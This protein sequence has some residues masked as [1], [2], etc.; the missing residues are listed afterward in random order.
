M[1][2]ILCVDTLQCIHF[3]CRPP[4]VTDYES[5]RIK[6]QNENVS[7][8]VDPKT[9][10]EVSQANKK[11][12]RLISH[13]LK[14]FPVPEPNAFDLSCSDVQ[15]NLPDV[16][17]GKEE[18]W[19]S[20]MEKIAAEVTTSL[21]HL[22]VTSEEESQY[23][24]IVAVWAVKSLCIDGPFAKIIG[25]NVRALKSGL[26][27]ASKLCQT[28]GEL[29]EQLVHVGLAEAVLRILQKPHMAS[30]IKICGVHVLDAMTDWPDLM[31]R[32]LFGGESAQRDPV[33]AP[34]PNTL[35]VK[36]VE[37]ALLPQAARVSAAITQLLRKAHVYEC[38][39]QVK[40][41][42]RV[43]VES[44]PDEYA[45]VM[46]DDDDMEED[47]LPDEEVEMVV[48]SSASGDDD[49]DQERLPPEEAAQ[50]KV[51]AFIVC[52]SFYMFYAFNT[53]KSSGLRYGSHMWK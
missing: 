10:Q 5:L 50:N 45:Y 4:D 44:V 42:T 8:Y 21:P 22:H 25:L 29:A 18:E 7:D 14:H 52:D 38:M 13:G 47:Y 41:S 39:H 49:E 40:T 6:L 51:C 34:T 17:P 37:L 53:P 24:T 27:L 28:T 20:T 30:S 32:F 43:M 2:F 19:V 33:D 16:L 11:L 15:G 26:N 48:M 36:V 35:Y 9:V 23:Y 46:D 3:I 12:Q 1:L 31:H